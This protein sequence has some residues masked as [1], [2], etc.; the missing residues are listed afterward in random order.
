VSET[1]IRLI[2]KKGKIAAMIIL[3]QNG[4]ISADIEEMIRVYQK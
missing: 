4:K 2:K 3:I 1:T